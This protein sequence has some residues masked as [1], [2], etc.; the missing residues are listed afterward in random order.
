MTRRH[1]SLIP[2]THDHHHAL[3]NL[4]LLRTAADASGAERADAAR[5]FVAFFEAH[6]IVHFRE[7]EEAIFPLVIRHPQAPREGIE[8]ILVEHV[9][10]HALV[11]DLRRQVA[12]ADVSPDTMRELADLL[13]AHIRFE[14]DELFPAIERVAG[15]DLG[16]VVLAQR[17]RT[18][19]DGS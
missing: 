9:Q 2:L 6:S 12:D 8:R 10:L 11:G 15:D 17:D 4:R 3:H 19:P 7:E 5:A 14:E 1:D 13:R 16:G 18:K